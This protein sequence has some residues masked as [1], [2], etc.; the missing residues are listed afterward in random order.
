MKPGKLAD[1]A[2][3]YRRMGQ[4]TIAEHWEAEPPPAGIPTTSPEEP[5]AKW[6]KFVAKCQSRGGLCVVRRG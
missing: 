3:Y 6:Q 5:V 1:A 2:R 4:I